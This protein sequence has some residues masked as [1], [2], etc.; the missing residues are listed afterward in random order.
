MSLQVLADTS[1]GGAGV[2]A[3]IVLARL[4]VPLLIPRVP[5]VIIV[6]LIIDAADQT[7]LA[8][9]TDV[10]T[11]EGGPYQ[12]FDKALDIY[13][14]AIAYLAAMRNWTSDAAFQIARFLLFY[15]LV[16]VTL[17]EL[18]DSRW[19]L[20]V[21]PN[22]FEYFFIAYELIRLRYEPSRFSARA[23]FL[24]AA[25][26]WVFIKLPQ[27]YWIHIAKLDFTDALRDHPWL[28][29]AI[30]LALL[31]AAVLFMRVAYPRL[32]T[33]DWG[34]RVRA[35]PLP[36]SLFDISTRYAYRLRGARFFS[37]ELMEAVV[38]LALICVIFAEIL[39]VE[40]GVLRIAVGVSA[41]VVA[42]TAIGFWAARRGGFGP[43]SASARFV[44]VLAV[45]LLFV[46]L[47]DIALTE[48]GHFDLGYGLFFAFLITLI[49][50]LYGAYRPVY[51]GRFEGSP[52]R[53]FSLGDFVRRVRLAEP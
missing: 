33:P 25:G 9:F 21:F 43:R 30:V 32:P 10:D 50:T 31:L 4:L 29:P 1:V 37:T 26:I 46:A 8:T 28:G 18:T 15:R 44:V 16:G 14:L 17:F 3:A 13:Y 22:T 19:L 40:A 24:W 23:W 48:G 12:S 38:L 34:W 27:E 20:I 5:L 39:A 35:S 6:V 2:V 52:L 41:I 49:V 51:Y 7:I 45:N 42:D 11:G 36:W 53:V 47:T